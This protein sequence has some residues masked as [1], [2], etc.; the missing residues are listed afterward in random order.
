[1]KISIKRHTHIRG[2]GLGSFDFILYLAV[3]FP[4]FISIWFYEVVG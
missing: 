2:V 4:N 1:M 3:T